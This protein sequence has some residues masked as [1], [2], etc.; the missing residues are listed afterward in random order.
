MIA[1]AVQRWYAESCKA[2]VLQEE[3]NA[4]PILLAESN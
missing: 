1:D 4:I 3:K 2:L